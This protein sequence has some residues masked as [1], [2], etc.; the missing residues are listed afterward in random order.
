[1][2]GCTADPC[3]VVRATSVPPCHNVAAALYAGLQIGAESGRGKAEKKQSTAEKKETVPW[4]RGPNE[5]GR[6]TERPAPGSGAEKGKVAQNER[7]HASRPNTESMS[8]GICSENNKAF[9]FVVRQ[10]LLRAA[11]RKKFADGARAF[12]RIKTQ[13]RF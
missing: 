11:E 5:S 6:T 1:M 12:V 13:K 4:G 8:G 7:S 3:N 9:A 2:K 10:V